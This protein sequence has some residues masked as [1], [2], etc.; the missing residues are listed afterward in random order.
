MKR[1][2]LLILGNLLSKTTGTRSVGEE[3]AYHLCQRR[4][5][6]NGSSKHRNKLLKLL[7]M[8]LTII[9]YKRWYDV[10]YIEVYSGSAFIWAELCSLLLVMIKK[11]IVLTLH[12]GNL[13]SF[14][15]RWPGRVQRVLE[16]AASVTTPSSY[17]QSSLKPLR[18]DIILLR[19]AVELDS[20]V[21][22][23]RNQPLPKIAWLR[24]FHSIY[25]PCMVV[26]SVT[27]LQEDY[28][29]VEVTMYGPDKQD[30]SLEA[31]EAL[32]RKMRFSNKIHIAGSIPKTKVPEELASHDIFLNTTTAE[33]F[34]VAVMEAAA[35]GMC[36]VT[37]DVGELPYIW[38]HEYDALLVPSGDAEAMANAVRRILTEPGLAERLSKNARAKAE[39]FDWSCI[40]P[41]WETLL[42]EVIEKHY[43][44]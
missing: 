30:G 7:D 25:N 11:P 10:V 33:S 6:V 42:N 1:H 41:Q 16:R 27:L 18:N 8:L 20:Y 39:Q 31:V 44:G 32:T 5:V 24:A 35:L 12:G 21:F 4:W 38:T 34:G 15:L 40:L 36:I 17:I 37:T 23:K 14:S 9:R 26:E 43:H 28:P 22:R 13:P 3:L 2:N 19:N 29:Q